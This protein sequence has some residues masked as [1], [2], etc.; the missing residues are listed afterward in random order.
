MVLGLLLW[1]VNRRALCRFGPIFLLLV[2]GYVGAFWHSQG[3]IGFPAQA[4]KAVIAPGQVSQTDQSSDLYR[5]VE[6]F[7]ISSTIHA[8][9]LT[10]IGFGQKFYRPAPLPDISFFPF[11]QYIPHNSIL[12]IWMKMGIGG[13]VTMLFLFGS[14]I[15]QGTRAIVTL[16]AVGTGSPSSRRCRTW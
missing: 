13:F 7:D 5:V 16:T 8:K 15:R 10:G 9:P 2:V 14:A 6:N 4:L 3:T 11:Y 12:W 1:K